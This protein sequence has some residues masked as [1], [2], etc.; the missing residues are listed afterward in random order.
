MEKEKLKNTLKG[1]SVG[2][3]LTLALSLGAPAVTLSQQG[4]SG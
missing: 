1:V 3:L 4:G 2:A